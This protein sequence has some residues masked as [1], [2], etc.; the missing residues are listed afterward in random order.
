MRLSHRE[1]ACHRESNTWQYGAERVH[2]PRPVMHGMHA[3]EAG[4]SETLS[5]GL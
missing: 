3:R 1:V 5:E 4:G 2:A